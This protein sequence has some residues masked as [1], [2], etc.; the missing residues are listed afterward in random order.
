[1]NFNEDLAVRWAKFVWTCREWD[2]EGTLRYFYRIFQDIMNWH[3]WAWNWKYDLEGQIS[4]L[5]RKAEARACQWEWDRQ[6]DFLEQYK[7]WYLR[8]DDLDRAR[9]RLWMVAQHM[10]ACRWG[11]AAR[12]LRKNR[13]EYWL[14]EL[15][16]EGRERTVEEIKNN[17]IPLRRIKK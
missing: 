3:Y 16:E 5:A 7:A 8:S 6:A 13:D 14:Y 12:L 11:E 9:L 2:Y 17:I 1:M 10:R 15:P 4:G